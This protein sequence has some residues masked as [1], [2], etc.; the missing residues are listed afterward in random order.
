LQ[1]RFL[2]QS[3]DEHTEI[4][5]GAQIVEADSVETLANAQKV[6]SAVAHF[7][8]DRRASVSELRRMIQQLI[9]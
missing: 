6:K 7:F 5:P 4:P 1:Q 8:Q 2:V 9:Q 3:V